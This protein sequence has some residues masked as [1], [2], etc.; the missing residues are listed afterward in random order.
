MSKRILQVLLYDSDR[1]VPQSQLASGIFLA[2]MCPDTSMPLIHDLAEIY[3][4]TSCFCIRQLWQSWATWNWWVL[5]CGTGCWREVLP[6]FNFDW[7]HVNSPQRLVTLVLNRLDLVG[8]ISKAPV[9]HRRL[10]PGPR[11]LKFLRLSSPPDSWLSTVWSLILSLLLLCSLLSPFP[12]VWAFSFSG[13]SQ[14]WEKNLK[15]APFILEVSV[16]NVKPYG[17][18]RY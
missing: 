9:P 10:G 13:M 18:Y 4:W 15:S 1:H 16:K 14:E 5:E 3:N 7:F 2:E 6:F 17:S 11:S 8:L 12:G